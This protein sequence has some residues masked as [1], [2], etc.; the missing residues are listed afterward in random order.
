MMTFSELNA[1]A[2]QIENEG[3]IPVESITE[4]G[5]V[6]PKVCGIYQKVRPFLEVIAK[7]WFLPKKWRAPIE[8]L[9]VVLDG[10]CPVV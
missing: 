10:L 1:H 4:E 9:M 8:A 5:D 7:A 2:D 6:I 3:L